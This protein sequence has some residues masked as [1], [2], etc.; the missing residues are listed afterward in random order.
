MAL[1]AT[2]LYFRKNP[3]A[4]FILG[5][6]VLLLGAVIELFLGSR[7]LSN[8]LGVYA[9]ASLII[10]IMLQTI[11]ALKDLLAENVATKGT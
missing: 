1:R 9:F 8:D 2:Y 7:T 5:F 3:G 10:G 6:Q 11:R 4:A